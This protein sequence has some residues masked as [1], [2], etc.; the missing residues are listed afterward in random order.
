MPRNCNCND[1]RCSCV[2]VAGENITISGQGRSDNP[3]VISSSAGGG[4]GGGSQ[5]DTGDLKWTSR[6]SAPAGW[7]VADGSSVS[8]SAYPALFAA[9]GIV[10]GAGDG[11]ST[12]NLPDYTGKFMMGSDNSHPRGSVGGTTGVQMTAAMLTA[13]AH[14]INHNHDAVTSS[15]DGNHDHA[16]AVNN[17]DGNSFERLRKADTGGDLNRSA[18]APDGSHTH[19]VNLPLFEGTSGT[20]GHADPAPIPTIPPYT[21]ALPLIK[22]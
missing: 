18:I 13:H 9:I 15:S 6:Q 1:S 3:M 22:T 5:W 16:L 14:S 19:T 10:Y 2:I 11:A 17:V 21:T 12:F 8:R 20:S 4:G 7:L